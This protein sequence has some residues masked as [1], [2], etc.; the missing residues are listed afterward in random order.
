MTSLALLPPGTSAVV[1]SLPDAPGL[2]R[3]LISLGLTPGAEVCM[4]QNRGRG[5]IILEVHGAR[6][7]LGRGQA[8]RVDVEAIPREM[9]ACRL[10]K[11]ED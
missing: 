4:L 8:E 6:L 5:P 1:A 10:G 9:D 3:R 2:A 7:A 11:R